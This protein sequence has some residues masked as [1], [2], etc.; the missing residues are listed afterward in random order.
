MGCSPRCAPTSKRIWSRRMARTAANPGLKTGACAAHSPVRQLAE[1]AAQAAEASPQRPQP[2]A[3]LLRVPAGV[4]P[5][6]QRIDHGRGVAV[7]I[8][9]VLAQM[10]AACARGRGGGLAD[11]RPEAALGLPVTV[12]NGAAGA[13][14]DGDPPRVAGADRA[15]GGDPAGAAVGAAGQHHPHPRAPVGGRFCHHRQDGGGDFDLSSCHGLRS[16]RGGGRARGGVRLRAAAR[17]LPRD[18]R[19]SRS[20]KLTGGAQRWAPRGPGRW[21]CG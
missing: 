7:R 8:V 10:P 6:G 9:V 12:G 2:P 15:V 16:G 17:R 11:D 1:H 18:P 19:P 20:R 13:E 21:R 14:V 4:R 5:V 3:D